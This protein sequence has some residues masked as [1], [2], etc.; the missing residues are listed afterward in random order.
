MT[1][2][3]NS[4]AA[5][6]LPAI[7][8]LLDRTDLPPDGLA[9]H[10][11]TTLVARDEEAIIGSAALEVYDEGALLRSVAVEPSYQGQGIGQQLTQAVLSLAKEQG[12]RVVY[13]LTETA[14]DFFPRFGFQTVARQDV[15]PSVQ[16]SVEFTTVCPTS[17]LVMVVNLS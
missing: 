7:L 6:D 1:I 3:I 8:A 14:G 4:A 2:L 15:A 11:S 10:L 13:L 16:Q 5:T 9:D 12:I 17:A